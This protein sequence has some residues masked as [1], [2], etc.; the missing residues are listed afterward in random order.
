MQ[1]KAD[2]SAVDDPDSPEL[3]AEGFR[4]L[5][6]FLLFLHLFAL[7]VAVASNVGPVSAVRRQLANVP[8]VRPYLQWLHMDLG[9]NYH[10][11]HA[12][13]LDVDHVIELELGQAADGAAAVQFPVQGLR[14]RVRAR[15]YG[16]LMYTLSRRLG[17]DSVGGVLPVEISQRLLAERQIDR[18][19]HQLAVKRQLLIPRESMEA[20]DPAVR[21]PYDPQWYETVYRANLSFFQSRLHLTK[22]A[23]AGENAAVRQE[24]QP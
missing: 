7:F 23:G 21:D 17:D 2:H 10:F 16:N 8:L 19:K 5:L 24:T 13:E 18:G 14:P 11:T 9:Y 4:T 6:S 12:T 20:L 1:S 3:P 15:R 22:A